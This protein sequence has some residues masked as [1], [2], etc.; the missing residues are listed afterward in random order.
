M[1]V[2]LSESSN[3]NKDPLVS[4]E[5]EGRCLCGKIRYRLDPGPR[6]MTHCHCCMCRQHHGAAFATFV[7]VETRDFSYLA[8]QTELSEYRDPRRPSVA[9]GFCPTCGSSLTWRHDK[10]A[11]TVWVCAGTLTGDPGCRPA[12]HIYVGSMAPWYAIHDQVPR[13]ETTDSL[14]GEE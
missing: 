5:V 2:G 14:L 1:I 7:A 11:A 12:S 4:P 3:S 10:V 6:A 8:E 9:R 13:F